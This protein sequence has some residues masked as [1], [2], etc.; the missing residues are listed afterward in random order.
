MA[1]LLA[2]QM[3]Q[4][5]QMLKARDDVTN[6]DLSAWAESFGT[7]LMSDETEN[8]SEFDYAND[9]FKFIGVEEPGNS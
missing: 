2:Y 5:F 3:L 9:G 7:F 6:A 4:Q 8:R 1:A